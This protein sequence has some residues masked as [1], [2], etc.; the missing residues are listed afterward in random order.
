LVRTLELRALTL[1]VGAS[2]LTPLILGKI[3]PI[4]AVICFLVLFPIWMDLPFESFRDHKLW[5]GFTFVSFSLFVLSRLLEFSW[6]HSIVILIGFSII[7]EVYGERRKRAHIRILSILSFFIVVA[8]FRFDHGFSLFIGILVFFFGAG[9]TLLRF[10]QIRL[11]EPLGDS[12]LAWKKAAISMVGLF[13]FLVP[14]SLLI[15]W[16]IP[17]VRST[18]MRPYSLRDGNFISAFSDRVSLSDIGTINQ[19]NRHVLDLI[20]KGDYPVPTTYLTGRVLDQFDGSLWTSSSKSGRRPIAPNPEGIVELKPDFKIT[21]QQFEISMKPLHGN[22][23]FFFPQTTGIEIDDPIVS[24]RKMR[25]YY[26]PSNYP[27]IL[28]YILHCQEERWDPPINPWELDVYLEVEHQAT[29]FEQKAQEIFGEMTPGSV[30]DAM[31]RLYSYYQQNYLYTLEINNFGQKEPLIYFLETA[32]QG[33]CELFASSAAMLLRALG[34]PTR[35]VTGFL[36]PQ[37]TDNTF[38][39]VTEASAHAWVE[40]WD[41]DSWLTYDPTGAVGLASTS[42]VQMQLAKLNRTWE[43]LILQWDFATQ[44]DL[45]DKLKSLI[46]NPERPVIVLVFLVLVFLVGSVVWTRLRNGRK[47]NLFQ[48]FEQALAQQFPERPSHVSW[49]HYVNSLPVDE[50][51][52]VRLESWIKHY[53]A[54]FFAPPASSSQSQKL[55]Q[56]RSDLRQLKRDLARLKS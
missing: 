46:Q 52:K 50:P 23:F 56:L 44:R 35:L 39:H 24:E 2:C 25:H 41:G 9:L 5:K 49:R 31:S 14:I 43:D 36:L 20:P 26:H 22:P 15:F 13:I 40:V 12:V 4:L 28:R 7:Y 8:Q 10:R 38:Y 30:Q 21:S 29:Y 48:G 32:K 1:L 47:T 18:S 37:M 34:I 19:S 53:F 27:H 16:L 33:H 42:W 11:V 17:R 3:P 6:F 45:M 55:S 51:I 54:T